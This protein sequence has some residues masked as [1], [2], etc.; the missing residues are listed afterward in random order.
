MEGRSAVHCS[1]CTARGP[2]VPEEGDEPSAFIFEGRSERTSRFRER[3]ICDLF[4]IEEAPFLETRTRNFFREKE[5]SF[6]S[7]LGKERAL[8]LVLREIE[9]PF[10]AL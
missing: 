6:T 9:K 2:E 3:E 7:L 4:L 1:P 8:V 5:T 10:V